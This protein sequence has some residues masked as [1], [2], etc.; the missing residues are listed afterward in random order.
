MWLLLKEVV[1]HKGERLF[2]LPVIIC[3]LK[4]LPVEGLVE[5]EDY[6]FNV[7]SN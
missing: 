7:L 2:M 6:L 1:L 5:L 4:G 3:Y